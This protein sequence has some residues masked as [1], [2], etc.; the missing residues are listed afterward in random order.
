MQR[1]LLQTSDP[2]VTVHH[3]S[4]ILNGNEKGSAA[5]SASS[6]AVTDNVADVSVDGPPSPDSPPSPPSPATIG[7]LLK[8]QGVIP[9]GNFSLAIP[10]TTARNESLTVTLPSQS[11]GVSANGSACVP[12]VPTNYMGFPGVRDCLCMTCLPD[13]AP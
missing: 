13:M 7:D 11:F 4:D 5:A 3:L 9:N 2:V 10:G 8:K 12:P 6:S 1:L